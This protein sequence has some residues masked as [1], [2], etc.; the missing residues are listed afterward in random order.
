MLGDGV[1]PKTLG[2]ILERADGN[3]FY[4]E[5]LVRAVAEG[6]GERLPETVLAMAQARLD[7][8]EPDARRTLRAG[9]VYGNSFSQGGVQ[10]L[11]GEAERF[12]LPAWLATLADRE[13]LTRR[14]AS[15]FP[16][17]VDYVF[18]NS[19]LRDAAYAT[20]TERD[21]E[22]G[23]KLAGDF[24]QARGE[25]DPVALAE[26]FERGRD[27]ER[28]AAGWREAADRALDANDFTGA[29]E[30]AERGVR[31]GASGETLGALR[32][33]QAKGAFW[34]EDAGAA[35]G[36]TRLAMSLLA[37]GTRGWFSAAGDVLICLARLGHK[38]ELE[39]LTDTLLRANAAPDAVEEQIIAL[40]RGSLSLQVLASYE[41]AAALA[42]RLEALA[43]AG[44]AREASIEAWLHQVHGYQALYA[45][46][47]GGYVK[48]TEASVAGFERLGD[49]RAACT[50]RANLGD[51]LIGVG[52]YREAEAALREALN[53]AERMGIAMTSS[54]GRLNLGL[55]LA[56]R[57]AH[58]EALAI[59]LRGLEQVKLH[60]DPRLLGAAHAYLA[61]LLLR[62]GNLGNA[63][64]HARESVDSLREAPPRLPHALAVLARILLQRGDVEKAQAAVDEAVMLAGSLG[65]Q[66]EGKS[67]VPLVHAEVLHAAGRREEASLAI[68]DARTGLLERAAKSWIRAC[69]GA[70][71]RTSTTTRARCRSPR[72]GAVQTESRPNA[73]GAASTAF[74]ARKTPGVLVQTASAAGSTY[75]ALSQNAS[76]SVTQGGATIRPKGSTMTRSPAA[77]TDSWATRGKVSGS[78]ARPARALRRCSRCDTMRHNSDEDRI[79]PRPP[80]PNGSGRP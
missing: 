43:R 62:T 7:A 48:H 5:E 24:L 41:R 3:A 29:I 72:R 44:P 6:N 47:A 55:A 11:V 9:S 79:N 13:L 2:Q 15:A 35:L 77:V 34:S 46:D 67:L 73:R 17:D 69:A 50:Q 45:G 42:A 36:R 78:R 54:F 14:P 28:A 26:H 31:C 32:L 80:R 64:A 4:L 16:G 33:V 20:L 51:A 23:H 37:E 39:W 8:L 19:L 56:E 74:A 57:G 65:Q 61:L 76:R 21:R 25:P 38:D 49:H 66:E 59:E 75:S 12:D 27:L 58:D 53:R 22:L 60:R 70:S 18:R 10:A 52:M 68:R 40:G 71:S 63:E 1:D 30:R